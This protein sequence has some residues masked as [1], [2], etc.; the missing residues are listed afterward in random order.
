VVDMKKK[1]HLA[2]RR[3]GELGRN[4]RRKNAI[5]AGIMQTIIMI[6]RRLGL[7]SMRNP[8]AAK[9]ELDQVYS[10]AHLYNLQMNKTKPNPLRGTVPFN[11]VSRGLNPKDYKG[12]RV[13]LKSQ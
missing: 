3:S 8:R 12:S 1:P 7:F 11:N 9:F 10:K 2:Q 5:I 4:A 6:K 13:S